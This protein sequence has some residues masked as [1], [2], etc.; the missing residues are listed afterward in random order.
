MDEV[1]N[2]VVNEVTSEEVTETQTVT[3]TETEP[4]QRD[5]QHDAQFAAAR[6]AAEE[7]A[8]QAREE[9]ERAEASLQRLMKAVQGYGYEGSAEDIA[10]LLE[11]QKAQVSVEQY[12]EQRAAEQRRID[13]MIANSP[14]M[15]QA[16]AI[17]E[18]SAKMQTE[19]IINRELAEI[20]KIN[21]EVKSLGDVFDGSERARMISLL[22]DPSKKESMSLSEAYKATAGRANHQPDNKAH[23]TG[24]NIGEMSND[25]SVPIPEAE[26]ERWKIGFPN[27]TM[28]ELTQKYNHSLL[29]QKGE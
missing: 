29:R 3:E 5:Y 25:T 24:L 4:Q 11:A 27:A 16:Q 23:M 10:D 2:E 14:Q 8:R 9:Q 20:R 7:Q 1:V 28:E 13:E 19:T 17:I 22:S 21:P 6:R 15:L 18:H 12:R 26:L